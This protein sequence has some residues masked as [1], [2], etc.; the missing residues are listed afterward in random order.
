M[1]KNKFF[2]LLIILIGA[3]IMRLYGFTNPVLDWHSWRQVDTSSVS[4]N[5]VTHGFTVL[6]PTFHDLSKGVSLLDNP[7]GYRFVEFPFYNVLQAGSFVLFKHF[8]L[9]EW[10]RLVSIFASLITVVFLY[11][12]VEKYISV[13]AGLLVAMFF[14]FAPYSIY[15]SRTL[16]PDTLMV[17]F[18]ISGLYFFDRWVDKTANVSFYILS[19]LL[20]ACAILMKPFVLFFALS[21][22]VISWNKFGKGFLKRKELW[23]FLIIAITPFALWRIWMEQ[24]PQGIPQSNWLF[25][26]TGIRFKGA[27]FQWL[28]ADRI[29]GLIL[30]YFGLPFVVIGI[31]S[32]I[33]KEGLLFLSMIISS[34]LYV[35]VIA[36]GNVQH[37]YYQILIFPTIAILF[38]KGADFILERGDLFNKYTSYITVAVSILF[39]FAFS[40]YQIRTYYSLQ[41][42]D[43]Y[44]V[45]QIADQILPKN[46]KVV[47]PFGGDTSFLYYVNR[48]GWPVV[49][50][51]FYQLIQEGAQYMVFVNPSKDE[52][53]V[54]T[55]F[56]TTQSGTN[57]AIF[58]LTRPTQ[59]GR[60]FLEKEQQ[61]EKA[62]K[63]K[64]T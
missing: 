56:T 53:H 30:G 32:K 9:E 63:Q 6:H 54:G 46:A 52:L 61:T 49:D 31:L 22:L 29:A 28:F 4:R 64:R 14:A 33:K 37:D 60:R 12:F 23:L 2:I 34:F 59:E 44:S 51:P 15:Y 17:T 36:T 48:Q 5:F 40:W 18:M 8:T 11:L 21:Y 16:L 1:M 35:S 38:V 43:A 26:G 55:L 45:G 13:R 58:D 10:G 25:N 20:T 19:L 42:I 7:N 24:Y 57:Y 41:H 47:A 27:F 39:M 62:Q 3:F 50:R